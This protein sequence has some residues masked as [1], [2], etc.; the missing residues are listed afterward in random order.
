METAAC[1]WRGGLSLNI[2]NN[3]TQATLSSNANKAVTAGSLLEVKSQ[4]VTQGIALGSGIAKGGAVGGGAGLAIQAVE[5][6]NRAEVAG[7]NSSTLTLNARDISIQ[8][9]TESYDRGVT[10]RDSN[11]FSAIAYSGQ[12]DADVGLAGALG[13]NLVGKNKVEAQLGGG[14]VSNL[15]RNLGVVASNETATLAVADG[16]GE[17]GPEEDATAVD[18]LFD[19]YDASNEA[20]SSASAGASSSSSN[21]ASTGGGSSD[22]A[23]E[24]GGEGSDVSLGVGASLALDISKT[25]TFATIAGGAAINN[26]VDISLSASS[27]AAHDITAEAAAGGG[28]SIVPLISLIVAEDTTRAIMEASAIPIVATGDVEV[29]ASQELS[30]TSEALGEAGDGEEAPDVAL[31]MSVDLNISYSKV[32]AKIDRNITTTGTVSLSATGARTIT[33]GA[34]ASVNGGEEEE[35]E[36]EEEGGGG[37]REQFRRRCHQCH[38]LPGQSGQRTLHLRRANRR[39]GHG[40]R[41]QC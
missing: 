13:V 28:I 27:I 38:H 23:A 34:T 40:R 8:A 18:A 11:D 10:K 24:S 33:A 12:G 32:E 3:N 9:L 37:G 31:G 16:I 6:T 41:G 7:K 21:G 25:E 1:K 29:S 35:A 2:I 17:D 19:L 15:G 5:N 26:A 30:V 36:E 22:G 4:S 14:T 39:R 20:A